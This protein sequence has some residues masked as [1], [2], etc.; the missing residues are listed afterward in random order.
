MINHL[1]EV[2]RIDAI[3]HDAEPE[4]IPLEPLLRQC[5][6][7]AAAHHSC[8]DSEVFTFDV[9]P[10]V[11]QARPIM[12]EMIFGNLLDNAIKYGGENPAVE[13]EV[14]VKDRD[15]I[16]TRISDN[17]EGV[18]VQHRKK[19]F[20]MFYRGGSEL[21]RRQ[22]GTGLGLYIVR[23]LVHF[24]KGKVTIHDR[25]GQ[26]GCVFEVELPGRPAA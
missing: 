24:L 22:K 11:I 26:P 2:A 25:N 1:L 14:R 21:E 19:I 15:R 12:L 20:K 6:K 9:E 3:G 7:N 23:T 4:D 8:T 18:S 17:G 13:V 10:S 16:L 5:A